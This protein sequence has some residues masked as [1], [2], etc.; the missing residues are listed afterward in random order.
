MGVE[1]RPAY[2]VPAVLTLCSL[3]AKPLA[4]TCPERAPMVSARVDLSHVVF[5]VRATPVVNAAQ[6]TKISSRLV[7]G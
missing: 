6:A 2:A 5:I 7:V 3:I 1:A 4:R